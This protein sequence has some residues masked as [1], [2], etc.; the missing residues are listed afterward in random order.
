MAKGGGEVFEI[1][2]DIR[3]QRD[4]LTIAQGK[5]NQKDIEK[6]NKKIKELQ[7]R[8]RT[9]ASVPGF[10]DIFVGIRKEY[11]AEG[12]RIGYAEGTTE[13]E[14]KITETVADT[15]GAPTPERQV[16][17]LSYAE[18]R[19]KLPKEISDDIVELLANSTEALQ[20][21]AYITTQ[22]DVSNFNVKYGVNLVIPQTA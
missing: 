21:F 2:E 15:P 5:N 1:T 11:L 20:D 16:L 22:D 17:K 8:L 7:A 4:K 12:G 6:I 13:E 14:V 10:D 3:K 9:I 18:L 19:N